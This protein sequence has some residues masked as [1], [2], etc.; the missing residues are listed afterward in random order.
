MA[1]FCLVTG[2]KTEAKSVAQTKRQT[3]AKFEASAQT[4]SQAQSHLESPGAQTKA[5]TDGATDSVREVKAPAP[6]KAAATK[7]RSSPPPKAR[8]SS[9]NAARAVAALFASGKIKKT[10]ESAALGLKEFRL[11]NG[12]QVLLC[13]RHATPVVVNQIVYRIGSRN[14]AVGYTGS[15]HFLEHMMFKGTPRHDPLKKTGLDDLLKP[16]GGSN[17]ATT[18][19]DRTSYYEVVPSKYLDLCL[20]LD[21]DR[22]RNLLLR[23]S[24]RKSEMTV[25][26]NELEQ[27]EDEPSDLL[28][29][30]LMATAYREHPY[31]HPTIGWRSDV[32]GVPTSRLRQFYND[33]YF[34]NNAT[35]VIVGDFNEADALAKV[36]KYYGAI[37]RAPKKSPPV[38]TVEPPQEGE[39]RFEVV[40]GADLPMVSIGYHVPAAKHKDIFVLEVIESILGDASKHSSRLYKALVDKRLASDVYAFDRRMRD[41]GM[42]IVGA[43]AASGVDA[44]LLEKGLLEEL[45]KISNEPV[46]DGELERAQND[47]RK[48][49]KLGMAD[50]LGL[51]EQL[52]DAIGDADWQWLASYDQSIKAVT[53]ADVQRVA[54]QYFQK[55]NRTVGY[56][57]PKAKAEPKEE[58]KDSLHAPAATA[59]AKPAKDP[60]RQEKTS[61]DE[62]PK[63]EE[64]SQQPTPDPTRSDSNE[65]TK[66][67]PVLV[68]LADKTDHP[69]GV[70][71]AKPNQPAASIKTAPAGK[72]ALGSRVTRA[73]LPNGLTMLL[74]PLKGTGTVAIS[75]HVRCGKYYQPPGKRQVPD[76]MADLLTKGSRNYSK[77]AIAEDLEFMGTS[78]DFSA[79]TF[80]MRFGSEVVKEDLP[81]LLPL[82]ADTLQHPLFPEE[83]LATSKKLVKSSIEQKK[84]DTT[85]NAWNAFRRALYKEQSVYHSRTF[86]QQYQDVDTI[87]RQDLVDFHAKFVTP[88]NTVLSVVGDFSPD[89]LLSDLS[90]LLIDWKGEAA[91]PVKIDPAQINS[92]TRKEVQVIVPDKSNID[93]CMGLPVDVSIRSP[94]YFPAAIGNAALGYD[95]FACRLSPVRDEFGYSYGISSF[96]VDDSYPLSPWAISFSVNPENLRPA[97]KLVHK[98]VTTYLKEGIRPNELATEKSHLTGAFQVA[99]R[100]PRQLAGRLSAC[101]TL[102]IGVDFIDEYGS[103]IK[104]VSQKAVNE[105]IRKYFRIDSAVTSIAGSMKRN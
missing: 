13:E 70:A 9:V 62:A 52:A 67:Q 51:A 84:A 37:A 4:Q 3:Q 28:D 11:S 22:M 76:L 80:F 26:R 16:I 96:F 42:F 83:E 105:A 32:E 100:S 78:I 71:A 7:E 72:G 59:P 56:Y 87:S 23:E 18:S 74:F 27:S 90:K 48:G 14:E 36:W 69:A 21:S 35:A 45:E 97:I 85:T 2:A 39:R 103:R 101:E 8:N 25:V 5:V 15:T 33:F 31:H 29:V 92:T 93:V 50:P 60:T 104:G 6:N 57:K 41:P 63:P 82:L 46:T 47:L 44:T 30:N 89:Q 10:G 66:A 54:K 68:S 77:N 98:I 58:T 81:R 79:D 34:P 1:A 40:R 38:Y 86:D 20:E 64:E 24:D 19:N 43:T 53:K 75:G 49:A 17:N 91:P 12:L 88:T 61:H 95:S 99:A 73:V 94:N 102:G 55:M 65:T